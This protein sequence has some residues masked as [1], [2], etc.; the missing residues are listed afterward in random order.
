VD[1]NEG[2]SSVLDRWE[3]MSD[4][5]HRERLI[6]RIFGIVCLSA[7]LCLGWYAHH[8]FTGIG[9]DLRDAMSRS[10]AVSREANVVRER[11]L[12]KLEELRP[13]PCDE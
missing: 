2:R 5:D 4:S 3:R 9:R 11:Y 8:I 10:E 6:G 1:L 12:R 7:V 13:C